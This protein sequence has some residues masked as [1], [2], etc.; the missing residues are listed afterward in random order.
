MDALLGCIDKWLARE[1]DPH[2]MAETFR[3]LAE[4]RA[5]H[6]QHVTCSCSSP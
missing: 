2:R 1:F 6:G 4:A 5:S 3:T